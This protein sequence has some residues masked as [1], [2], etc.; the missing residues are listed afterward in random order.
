M[1]GS[2]LD[3]ASEQLTG[4]NSLFAALSP[5]LPLRRF[6]RI[7]YR[8]R[9]LQPM[10]PDEHKGGKWQVFPTRDRPVPRIKRCFLIPESKHRFRLSHLTSSDSS[11][12]SDSPL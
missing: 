11:D 4:W 12:S 10:L 5:P 2:S 7:G 6:G 3:W 1:T 8:T 9:S